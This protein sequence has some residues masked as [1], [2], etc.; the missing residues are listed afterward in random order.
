MSEVIQILTALRVIVPSAKMYMV[1][2]AVRDLI[3][4]KTPKDYDY[5]IVGMTL[6]EISLALTPIGKVDEVG[7]SFG[8]IKFKMNN[9]IY[10]LSVPRTE[11][12]VGNL[13]TD[14]I[15]NVKD[16]SLL[17]DLTRRDFTMNAIAKDVETGE[18]LDPHMGQS[19][20][21]N[22]T[23]RCV[24]NPVDRF[25]EDPLRMIRAIQ[26]SVRLN[27]AISD[28]TYSAILDH[29]YF[30]HSISKDRFMEEFR[31][32]FLG[33]TSNENLIE[34]LKTSGIGYELFGVEF[35]PV[36]YKHYFDIHKSDELDERIITANLVAMFMNGGNYSVMNPTN[37]NIASIELA[38]N[39]LMY[40][41]WKTSKYPWIY[42]KNLRHRFDMV[43]GVMAQQSDLRIGKALSLLLNLCRCPLNIG[44][45]DIDGHDLIKIG[46]SGSA[47][48]AMVDEILYAILDGQINNYRS[49]IFTF[50]SKR[51]QI[52]IV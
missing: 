50:I 36:I 52:K 29:K 18:I 26:F 32:A 27:F 7:V 34:K 43:Y 4:K 15:V 38:R 16:V 20:I 25:V 23:I 28:E 22:K 40:S 33:S 9:V 17:D 1:G 21:Q 35:Q 49:E 14:F 13:H 44:E 5:I 24:G 2:G 30:L 47:I 31:K 12:K 48:G 46:F 8:I 39:L 19:D 42:A 45:L 11:Q 6:E 51:K 10:D 3:L 37:D 41:D